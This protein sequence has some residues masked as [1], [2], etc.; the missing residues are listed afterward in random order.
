VLL[1]EL[2][3]FYLMKGNVDQLLEENRLLLALTGCFVCLAVVASVY[4][5]DC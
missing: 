3:L 4:L 1:V 2:G 5:V